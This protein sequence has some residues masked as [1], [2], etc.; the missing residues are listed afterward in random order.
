MPKGNN[1]T[2]GKLTNEQLSELGKKSGVLS[3]AAKRYKK[4][5]GD[6]LS[7]LLEI[8]ITDEEAKEELKNAGF[9]DENMINLS[10][11]G[12]SL[13]KKALDGDVEAIRDIKKFTDEAEKAMI[14]TEKLKAD[15]AK[16]A[17]E[18]EAKVR[19]YAESI[20]LHNCDECKKLADFKQK[21]TELTN[22]LEGEDSKKLR[23]AAEKLVKSINI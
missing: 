1:P 15:L 23:T 6:S 17:A 13:Y 2:P 10:Y 14:E 11:L 9:N 21:A 16:K 19:K 3:G 8:D 4:E 7:V 18:V 12:Y 22:A 20:N 5:L